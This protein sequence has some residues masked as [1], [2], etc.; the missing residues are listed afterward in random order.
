MGEPMYDVVVLGGGGGGVPAA[1]RAS[2]LGGRVAVVEKKDLGG[3]CMNRGCIPFVHMMSAVR[4]LRYTAL[5]KSMGLNLSGLTKEYA[6]L[7][8]RRQELIAF[9]GQGVRSMLK[10]NK[11]TF[12]EGTGRIRGKGSLDVD[13]EKIS[14]KKLILATGT[15][16][17]KPDFPGSDLKGVVNTDYLLTMKALPESAVLCG[18]SPW[19]LEIA[20]FLAGFGCRVTLA[21]PGKRILSE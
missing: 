12:I 14:F 18:E 4:I 3:F 6:A 13:G 5:G 20:Q 7:P 1:V 15:R 21:V 10:K 9:M 19:L 11:A 16:W 8:R 2:Q 17:R